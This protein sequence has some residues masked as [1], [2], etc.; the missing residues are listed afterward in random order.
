MAGSDGSG[1][2]G[3]GENQD[4]SRY[5]AQHDGKGTSGRRSHFANLA[6]GLVN[7][8]VTGK[9]QGQPGDTK[10]QDGSA[11]WAEKEAVVSHLSQPEDPNELTSCCFPFQLLFAKVERFSSP[12]TLL[13]APCPR[14]SYSS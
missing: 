9:H 1:A 6:H 14:Q 3:E 8:A 4:A 7:V 12:V 5:D 13:F 2:H 10:S 11:D